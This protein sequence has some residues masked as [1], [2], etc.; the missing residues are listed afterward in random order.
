MANSV[1]KEQFDK[2]YGDT[3]LKAAVDSTYDG[4]S[5]T[6]AEGNI[7][8]CNP[9][10]YRL[11]G[12]P[13]DRIAGES[14]FDLVHQGFPVSAMTIEVME[15]QKTLNRIVHYGTLG[16]NLECLITMVPVFDRAHTLI[17]TVATYRDI[18]SLN[19]MKDS[20]NEVVLHYEDVLQQ[21]EAEK[22]EL[23]N[24]LNVLNTDLS[25]FNIYGE[26][27]AIKQ[28]MELAE[29][30]CHMD[31]TVL[32]TGESGVGKDVFCQMIHAY[33][34]SEKPFIKISCGAI[35]ENLLESELFG[36]EPG[37]FTGASKKGKTGIFE[38]ASG[39]IVFLDEIG[40]M[41]MNLQ[42]KLLTVLQDRKFYRVGGTKELTMDARVVAAT[43]QDLKE[44]VK[45]KKFRSDLY[46][47]LNVIPVK[48][49]PLRERKEDIIPIA[50]GILARLNDKYKKEKIFSASVEH[51]MHRYDWP[52]NIRELSNVVERMYA[53]S[54]NDMIGS[55]VLPE[56][57]AVL[58]TGVEMNLNL[59]GTLKE[60][61][62]IFEA[63]ILENALSENIPIQE[64]ADK[65]GLHISTLERKIKKH[66]LKSRYNVMK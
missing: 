15:S 35:P 46:Y 55:D 53:L 57:L 42:V 47:R 56:E 16:N 37:A 65:L 29:R 25:K 6:D 32:V 33:S 36:Y 45:N 59:K 34:G 17:G 40:E 10:Y 43:N 28:L 64:I 9:A 19:E 1:Y 49:P 3:V 31:S 13:T 21:S 27:K 5:F 38:L 39:G 66:H 58:G 20:L 52:G 41:S 30:V 24:K 62:D 61:M 60:R 23:W 26:S 11:T 63:K 7:L 48:I 22:L 2:K 8:Y 54:P 4:I 50:N 14:V 51:A 44:M 12:L 18:S